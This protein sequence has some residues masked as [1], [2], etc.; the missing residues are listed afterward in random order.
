MRVLDG[1][2]L[3]EH[4]D[5]PMDFTERRIFA[6]EEP[7]AGHE[8]LSRLEALEGLDT[9]ASAEDTAFQRRRETLDFGDP[10]GAD[11]SRRR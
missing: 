2:C 1:L 10:V 4:H 5:T 9:I 11:R 3:V 7:V 8:Y 6:L